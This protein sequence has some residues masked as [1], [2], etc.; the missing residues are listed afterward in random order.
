MLLKGSEAN[1]KGIYTGSETDEYLFYIKVGVSQLQISPEGQI[2]F[3][4]GPR[5]LFQTPQN[6]ACD[7]SPPK[8]WYDRGRVDL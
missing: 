3:K 7:Q 6:P 2:R 8:F 5:Y 4:L 1:P